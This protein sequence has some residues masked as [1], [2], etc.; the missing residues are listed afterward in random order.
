MR[1]S[2]YAQALSEILAEH[3]ASEH[4]RLLRRFGEIL[5]KRGGAH[6]SSRILRS[7]EK[8]EARAQTLRTITITTA[9]EISE[10]KAHAILA[11]HHVP[12]DARAHTL[13]RRVD[14]TL[15]GGAIIRTH[16]LRIDASCKRSLNDLYQK[17]I[18]S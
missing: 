2:H 1:A 13:E 16:A 7:L 17:L 10:E 11:E 3:P 18:S 4:P 6:L 9:H 5:T 8:K 15:T 12:F 14:T